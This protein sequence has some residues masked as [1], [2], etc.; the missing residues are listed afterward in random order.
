MTKTKWHL[1]QN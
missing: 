1:G